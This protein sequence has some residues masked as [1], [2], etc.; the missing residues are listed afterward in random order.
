MLQEVGSVANEC[1]CI[2]QDT[3]LS[4]P[5][6]H[7]STEF[8]RTRTIRSV[9][10]GWFAREVRIQRKDAKPYILVHTEI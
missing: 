6:H 8:N 1:L 9:R 7:F 4:L 5:L 3:F 10:Y 2:R